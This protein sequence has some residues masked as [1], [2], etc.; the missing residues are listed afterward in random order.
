MGVE[1]ALRDIVQHYR[2]KKQ[3]NKK[4]LTARAQFL[5]H[6]GKLIL[7]IS[8]TLEQESAKSVKEEK[9]FS[10]S[11]RIGH[12]EKFTDIGVVEIEKKYRKNL[13]EAGQYPDDDMP[14]ILYESKS[15]EPETT[16]TT[17]KSHEETP[18]KGEAQVVSVCGLISDADGSGFDSRVS[19]TKEIIMKRLGIETLPMKVLLNTLSWQTVANLAAVDQV[20]PE[21]MEAE[22][23]EE[24]PLWE[25]ENGEEVPLWEDEN[26]E[27]VPLLEDENGVPL[28]E[29]ENGA[30]VAWRV[31]DE[32]AWPLELQS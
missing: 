13:L 4:V 10:A 5:H 23:E 16:T 26:G 2:V 3:S 30:T 31:D 11:E 32:P 8:M 18:T 27:E 22:N 12:V 7:K 6:F 9:S 17:T 15:E 25:D 29:D 19:I 20:A 1:K 21:P 28:L 14:E 24:V